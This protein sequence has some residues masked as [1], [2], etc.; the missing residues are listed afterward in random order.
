MRQKPGFQRPSFDVTAINRSKCTEVIEKKLKI[1]LQ[2]ND[3]DLAPR[4]IS[5]NP[6]LPLS[7]FGVK[8]SKQTQVI[9]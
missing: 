3:L 2:A 7:K 6:K 5:G 8:R 1:L 4:Y 9:A